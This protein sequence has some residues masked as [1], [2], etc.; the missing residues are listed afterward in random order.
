MK[1]NIIK[2][3]NEGLKVIFYFENGNH[4]TADK[5]EDKMASDLNTIAVSSKPNQNFI[6]INLNLVTKVEFYKD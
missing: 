2:A 3:F 1:L 5:L 6:M 4:F